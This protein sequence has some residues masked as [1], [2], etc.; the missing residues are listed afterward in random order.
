MTRAVTAGELTK[1]RSDGQWARWRAIIDKPDVVYTCRATS[2]LVLSSYYIPFDG[3][4]G[5]Q[6]NVLKDMTVLV[7]TTSGGNERGINRIR[8]APDGDDTSLKVGADPSFGNVQDNDYITVLN[9]FAPFAKHPADINVDF[10]TE[11][12]D[13]F[14]NFI[15]VPVFTER[16]AVINVGGTVHWNAAGSWVPGSTISGYAWTFTG[17]T[18]YTDEDTA[19]PTAT[20]ETSGRFRVALT[21]T[22]ANSKTAVGYGWVYVL[23]ANLVPDTGIVID[24][25]EGEYQ[26]GWSCQ[27]VAYDRPTIKDRARVVIYS[28]DYFAN[29]LGSIGPVTD[30]ENLLMVGWILGETIIREPGQD[31]VEFTVAGPGAFCSSVASMPAGIVDSAFPETGIAD[32]PDWG[33]MTGLTIAKALHY[34]I[35]YRSTLATVLDVYVEDFTSIAHAISTDSEDLWGQLTE[36]AG[37]GLLDITSDRYGHIY[38]E[39]DIALMPVAGRSAYPTVMTFTDADWS[40][41][42]AIIRRQAGDAAMAEVEGKI[43]TASTGILTPVGGRAPGDY[44]AAMGDVVNISDLSILS[45][46]G[47]IQAAGLLA[48][49]FNAEYENISGVH[50]ANNHFIDLCPRQYVKLTIDGATIGTFPRR[51]MLRR[52]ADSGAVSLEMELEGEG[53]QWPAVSIDYPNEDDPPVD[54]PDYPDI[55][56]PPPPPTEPEEPPPTATGTDAVVVTSHDMRITA[57][58]DQASPAWTSII[59]GGP[60]TPVDSDLPETTN[61]TL[62]VIEAESIW[63]CTGVTGTPAWTEVWTGSSL[64]GGTIGALTRIRVAPGS[65]SLVYVLGYG[66][67][68]F[69][70]G[71][72][73]PFVLRSSNGGTTWQESWIQDDLPEATPYTMTSQTTIFAGD[74]VTY[75]FEEGTPHPVTQTHTRQD[76]TGTKDPYGVAMVYDVQ[77]GS[78]PGFKGWKPDSNGKT[79]G[80]QQTS[81]MTHHLLLN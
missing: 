47:A 36:I 5:T 13:E 37:Q 76:G 12:L 27:M 43:Y 16:I 75:E 69:E 61:D 24:E 7:G 39:R 10:D 71:N 8:V 81:S 67:Y 34:M 23:G 49:K 14:T 45:G 73:H 11:Y 26:Q 60:T 58:L 66:E 57:D 64:A 42:L 9:D 2:T 22:A 78:L 38:A 79:R 29:E 68:G 30:R 17:A 20:Y 52:D 32:I 3:A 40:G 1:L 62:Y 65:D 18:S 51:L 31:Y 33:K 15:P 44:P 21:V 6:T 72:N 59:S 28:E 56:P 46:A 53:G 48:G 54:I 41:E 55:P 74:V 63:K 25:I 70:A 19:T 4:S 50:P 77:S 80:L 35:N